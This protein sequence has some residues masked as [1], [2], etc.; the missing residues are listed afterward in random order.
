MKEPVMPTPNTK[1]YAKKGK[2]GKGVFGSRMKA[3]RIKQGWQV[4]PFCAHVGISESQIT[5]WE[6]RG[7]MPTFLN[8][9]VIATALKVRL[10]WLAGLED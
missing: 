10:D 2:P 7:V 6:N 1:P 3:E 5:A 4:R 9:V 8:A